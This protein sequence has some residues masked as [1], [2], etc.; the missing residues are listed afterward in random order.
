VA[1][2]V[3][4]WIGKSDDHRAPGKV[5]QRVFDRERRICH[6]RGTEIQTGQKWDLDHIVALINGG[7]N[8]EANLKPAHRKC[9]KDKTAADVAEK[10]KIAAI[11]GRHTGAI[12]PKGNLRSPSFPKFEKP[13]RID[14]SAIP[15]LPR[16]QLYRSVAT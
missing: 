11:R 4:E 1:R 16:S 8:R 2:T 9:H 14:K 7:E 10:S 15:D 3:E 6:L 13:P 5:R 12:R